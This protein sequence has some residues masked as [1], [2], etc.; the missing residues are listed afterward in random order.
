MSTPLLDDG[1]PAAREYR[2][3]L[4]L[5]QAAHAP[6]APPLDLDGL[7]RVTPLVEH[8]A[9]AARAARIPVERMLMDVKAALGLAR[10]GALRTDEDDRQQ[11]ISAA[12]DTY[13]RRPAPA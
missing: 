6:S 9:A 5:L 13:F 11:L 12:I 8:Y 7:R 1:T 3:A 4:A 10:A 2:Q